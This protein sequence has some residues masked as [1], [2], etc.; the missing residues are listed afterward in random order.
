MTGI[1]MLGGPTD[2]RPI[3]GAWRHAIGQKEEVVIQVPEGQTERGPDYSGLTFYPRGALVQEGVEAELEQTIYLSD[4]DKEIKLVQ[5]GLYIVLGGPATGKTILLPALAANLTAKGHR[6]RRFVVDEP[7]PGRTIG[8]AMGLSIIIDSF[9]RSEDHVLVLDSLKHLINTGGNATAGGIPREFFT[10]VDGIDA[11]ASAMG[12]AIIASVNP[13]VG[14][15]SDEFFTN[16]PPQRTDAFTN[17]KAALLGACRG[18]ITI[19]NFPAFDGSAN[20]FT[21]TGAEASIRPSSRAARQIA[22]WR[23]TIAKDEPSRVTDYTFLLD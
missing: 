14:P 17:I 18:V 22:A 16:R 4:S 1:Y 10:I 7:M 19:S 3:P 8:G 12:K 20:S 21:I 15:P 11:A 6:T 2:V 13:L 5:P 23:F 9:L